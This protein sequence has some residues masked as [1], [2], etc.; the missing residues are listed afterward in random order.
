MLFATAVKVEEAKRQ[1]S[2]IERS[3]NCSRCSGTLREVSSVLWGPQVRHRSGLRDW[4]E[5]LVWIFQAI[6]AM[7]TKKGGSKNCLKSGQVRQV[8]AV[9]CR[10]WWKSSNGSQSDCGIVIRY[11]L[12][13]VAGRETK[14][15]AT[16]LY[17]IVTSPS[18]HHTKQH[19]S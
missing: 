11:A 16:A 17:L 8:C 7:F 19:M 9:R 18:A 14:R 2:C 15:L 10:R 13:H 1:R 4:T 3:E 6:Q 12:D 5:E